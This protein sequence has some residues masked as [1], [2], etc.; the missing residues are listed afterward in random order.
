MFKY[1]RKLKDTIRCNQIRKKLAICG[2]KV[3]FDRSVMLN[4]PMN[5]KLHDYVHIQPDCRLYGM[6][7][8][9]IGMGTIIAHEVQILSS[10]H[11]YD[12]DD[13]ESLPYDRRF[14]CKKVVIGEYVWIGAR[15]IIL[16]GVTIGSGAVIGAGSVVTKDIPECAVVGGN[17]ARVI[18][19]RNRDVYNALVNSNECYIKKYK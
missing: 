15:A 16:P 18:K 9:E 5:I 13:L 3:H 11:N 17:P 8:I 4:H 14:D 10:N 2:E 12:S 1:I 6:G 7:G 19:Y